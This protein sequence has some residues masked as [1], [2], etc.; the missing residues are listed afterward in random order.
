MYTQKVVEHKCLVLHFAPAFKAACENSTS[1]WK[2][3][4][5]AKRREDSSKTP[6]STI[7]KLT[8]PGSHEH[9][10]IFIVDGLVGTP[11]SIHLHKCISFVH[12]NSGHVTVAWKEADKVPSVHSVG[13]DVADKEASTLNVWIITNRVGAFFLIPKGPLSARSPRT[14]R[15]GPTASGHGGRRDFPSLSSPPVLATFPTRRRS[16]TMP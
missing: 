5:D 9:F 1:A 16:A 6:L 4:Q 14:P 13:L 8:N 7:R 10:V 15:P 3:K 2:G 11:F 12:R